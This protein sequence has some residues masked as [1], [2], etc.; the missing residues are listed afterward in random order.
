M[1]EFYVKFDRVLRAAFQYGVMAAPV[2]SDSDKLF[3]DFA[4]YRKFVSACHRGF[5]KAQHTVLEMLKENANDVSL[6]S[7]ERKRRELLLRKVIDGIVFTLLKQK[8]YVTRR[9]SL[10]DEAPNLDFST[11][12]AVVKVAD[13]LNREDRMTFAAL[14]DLTTFVHIGDLI[15]IDRRR[16]KDDLSFIEVKEGAVNKIVAQQIEKY[17][18][19]PESLDQ[20]KRDV[21][22]DPRHVKQAQRMQRQRIRFQQT[23]E[24][25]RDDSGTDIKTG[26]PFRM[27]R[28]LINEV[29]Y[30]ETFNERAELALREGASAFTVNY[31]LHFG[32]S[33]HEVM[34]D[35][36]RSAR[37]NA[38]FGLFETQ[39]GAEAGLKAFYDA[40]DASGGLGRAAYQLSN[41]IHNQLMAVPAT[42]LFCWGVSRD[43][44]DAIIRDRLAI[45]CMVD[46]SALLFVIQQ[47]GLLPSLATRA[48]T[49]KFAGENTGALPQFG[50][51][52]IRIRHPKLP[53]EQLI[54]GGAFARFIN[55]LHSP[56]HYF[57]KVQ[58]HWHEIFGATGA[59][60]Q[61][62]TPR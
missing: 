53:G 27:N 54:M 20:I 5:E 10:H 58:E 44:I 12:D 59:G 15:R 19:V 17:A 6:T 32:M 55:N 9:V 41:V 4:H 24:V 26:R 62:S 8:T 40:N 3:E 35:R 22:I 48:E 45:Y 61:T 7:Y 60:D 37:V 34:R 23:A 11:I 13:R 28:Q 52:A 56:F 42:P 38:A 39:K 43:V 18:P 51:R 14:A 33:A 16:G 1:E 57:L 21:A 50:G 31:C 49:M 2:R 47:A 46:V 25:L 36:I 30:Q 29:H